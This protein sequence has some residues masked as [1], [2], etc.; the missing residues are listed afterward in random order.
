MKNEQLIFLNVSICQLGTNFGSL[1]DNIHGY[2][3]YHRSLP[4]E[5]EVHVMDTVQRIY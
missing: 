2:C 3:Y 4:Q 1:F 5:P